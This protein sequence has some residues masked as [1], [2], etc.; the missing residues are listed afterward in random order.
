[1]ATAAIHCV[2]MVRVAAVVVRA[3]MANSGDLRTLLMSMKAMP[4]LLI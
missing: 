2:V 3:L 4:Q 1:M